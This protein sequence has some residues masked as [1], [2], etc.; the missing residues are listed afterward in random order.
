[1]RGEE[2]IAIREGIWRPI[3]P[4]DGLRYF[5]GVERVIREQVDQLEL[6][7]QDVLKAAAVVGRSYSDE[8]VTKLTED[9]L[10]RAA[11]TAALDL[12]VT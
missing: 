4:V 12:L 11:L 9:E 10:D 6:A 7:A 3:Q 2:L 1:M 5:E 8:A